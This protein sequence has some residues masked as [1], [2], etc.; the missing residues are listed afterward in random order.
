M[1]LARFPASVSGL[2]VVDCDEAELKSILSQV[3]TAQRC[4]D[5]LVIRIGLRADRLSESGASAPARETVRGG[6]TVSAQQARRDAARADTAQA[7]TGLSEA[8]SC[9]RTSG[10]HVDSIA[11]HIAKLSPEQQAS[12]DYDDLLVPATE[13]PP[14]T[15][16]RLV[17]RRVELAMNDHG[18]G[19]T[20]SRQAASEFRHWFDGRTG[21]GRFSGSLDPERY[22]ALTNA[23]EAHAAS[24]AATTGE[25][26]AKTANLAARSL[27]EL[28]VMTGN[29]HAR[30]RLPSI[31]VI[32]DRETLANG[33]HQASIRQTEQGH[34]I[35]PESVG[36]LCCDAV[37]RRVVTDEHGVPIDVGRT[38]RTATDGQWAAIKAVHSTCGWDGCRAP[39][40]WC[41]AHHIKE[42]EHGGATDLD[43]LIPLCSRH[44]HLVHEGRWRL[45]LLPD[46]TLEIHR[47]DGVHHST[48]PT[49][50]RC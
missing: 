41:Q 6:G 2:D 5:G 3:R 47:P 34:D 23:V 20:V 12:F 8:V 37:L 32:V 19:D 50:R 4:L 24:I 46:R 16:D 33:P 49:P 14:E 29:R 1:V 42:W 48:V 38:Y 10:E 21:M 30:N 36:R 26:V 45:K 43:N 13:L 11:R 35:A 31:T 7:I 9:G 22:E 18:L 15:F 28:V 39:I 44:H 17:K 27:V 40:N 25:A